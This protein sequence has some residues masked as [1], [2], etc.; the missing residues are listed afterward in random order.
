MFLLCE[1][2]PIF[3]K[4][5]RTKKTIALL[6]IAGLLFACGPKSQNDSEIFTTINGQKI[7]LLRVDLAPDSAT[8]VGWSALFEDVEM[9][10]LETSEE[11]MI[12]N[13]QTTFTDHSLI[14]STQIGM[15]DPCRVYEFGMDGR[16][17]REIGGTGKGPGEHTG[18]FMEDATYH[19]NEKLL[20]VQFNGIYPHI[21]YFNDVGQL[22]EEIDCP[23]ELVQDVARLEDDI[24]VVAGALAGRP[25]YLRDSASLFWFNK[26]GEIIKTLERVDYPPKNSSGYTPW[27]GR[28]A[29]YQ[30]DDNW[31]FHNPGDDTVYQLEGL[32]LI[33]QAIFKYGE[34][35]TPINKIIDPQAWV[36]TYSVEIIGERE[37]YWILE[38]RVITKQKMNEYRPGQWGG[39]YGADYFNL[40]VDKTNGAVYNVKLT[41][42]LL[43]FVPDDYS[44]EGIKFDPLGQ[45]Y[46]IYQALDVVEWIDKGLEEGSIAEKKLAKVK[47]LRDKIDEESNP[48]LFLFKERKE[49]KI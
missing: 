47:A 30:Y 44:S 3:F 43:G 17:I 20:K 11:C 48:V 28:A 12:M 5:K 8:T 32:N 2:H 38:K 10:P 29:L 35:H 22:F 21:Q 9:I 33:P 31:H 13:S 14:L 16:F 19:P 18:Y 40:I 37:A 1:L 46:R 42:D 15:G 24:Y 49:Y 6:S 41:D 27:G 4:Y 45:T 39:E 7:S 23:V 25:E 34:K 36:G 26:T